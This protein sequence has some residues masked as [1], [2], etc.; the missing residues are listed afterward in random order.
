MI[1]AMADRVNLVTERFVIPFFCP[2]VYI[3]HLIPFPKRCRPAAL[4]VGSV[5]RRV[6]KPFLLVFGFWYGRLLFSGP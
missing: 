2:H 1:D 6:S 3:V 5:V 4:E